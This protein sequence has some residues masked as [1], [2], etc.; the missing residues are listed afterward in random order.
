V[1]EDDE[2]PNLIQFELVPSGYIRIG[3]R[4][5]IDNNAG[6]DICDDIFRARVHLSLAQAVQR[7]IM[8][9]DE[10]TNE[11]VWSSPSSTSGCPASAYSAG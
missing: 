9:M 2:D 3:K 6:C 4:I 8:L 5:C 11:E 7:W 1:L 10:F